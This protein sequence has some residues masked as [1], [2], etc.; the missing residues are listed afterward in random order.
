MFGNDYQIGRRV[1]EIHDQ[2]DN[3]KNRSTKE[4]DKGKD[5]TLRDCSR[6]KWMMEA[7][8]E[9]GLDKRKALDRALQIAYNEDLKTN[10]VMQSDITFSKAALDK[11]C[12]KDVYN[13]VR[14]GLLSGCH[15]LLIG[16]TEYVSRKYCRAIMEIMQ[17]EG[18]SCEVIHCSSTSSTESVIGTYSLEKDNEGKPV[19]RFC[20]SPLLTAIEDGGVC[21]LQSMHTM[22]SNVIERLN[23]V[24]E[25]SPGD[26]HHHV[27]R[28]DERREQPEF[29][30]NTQFRV[31]ATTSEKGLLAFSPALR[32]RFLEVFI[33]HENE[34][35]L[36]KSLKL[37]EIEKDETDNV[38]DEYSKTIDLFKHQELH[39]MACFATHSSEYVLDISLI[40]MLDNQEPIYELQSLGSHWKEA[41][42]LFYCICR[43][44]AVALCGTKGS[45]VGRKAVESLMPFAK[46]STNV[47]FK[48]TR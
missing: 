29:E 1:C 5:Y 31:I 26:G 24:L 38:I 18:Q 48:T 35:R 20:P 30:M 17:N 33:A 46:L 14:L 37:D 40:E 16:E 34:S 32:N 45:G 44:K 15:I 4:T 28:F 2:A 7:L 8:M 3:R 43:N 25:I 13:R 9:Q 47:I 21:V 22:K 41:S 42:R 23:S 19:P 39:R 36:E 12:W 27:I 10:P 6:T 11:E